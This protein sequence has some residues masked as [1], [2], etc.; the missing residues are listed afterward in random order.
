MQYLYVF[1]T[2]PLLFAYIELT[3][4]SHLYYSLLQLYNA[5]ILHFPLKILSMFSSRFR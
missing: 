3:F 4:Y 2:F 5:V 1:K